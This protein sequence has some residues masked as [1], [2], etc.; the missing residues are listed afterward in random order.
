ETVYLACATRE[1]LAPTDTGGHLHDHEKRH[2]AANCYC[3]SAEAFEEKRIRKKNQINHLCG[4]R[5]NDR[6]AR[7]DH[8]PQIAHHQKYR[9][10]GA[11]RER[12]IDWDVIR[13]VGEKQ[14]KSEE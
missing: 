5:L 11:D 9:D 12:P 14:V 7:T 8:D 6:K 3:Q 13:Q 1:P 4:S 10:Q 2:D